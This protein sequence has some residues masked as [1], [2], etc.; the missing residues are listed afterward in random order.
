M[1]WARSLIKNKKLAPDRFKIYQGRVI[2]TRGAT[3]IHVY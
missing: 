3:L 2:F 1:L